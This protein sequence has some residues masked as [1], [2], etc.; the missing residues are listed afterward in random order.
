MEKSTNSGTGVDQKAYPTFWPP[1][2]GPHRRGHPLTLPHRAAVSRAPGPDRQRPHGLP[3][4]LL[5]DRG[6]RGPDPRP[7]LHPEIPAAGGGPTAA[8]TPRGQL[9]PDAAPR[10]DRA[11]INGTR[12]ART[13]LTRLID[14]GRV[15]SRG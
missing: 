12:T 11:Q 8:A 7:A 6:H 1:P 10:Q 9:P 4:T 15:T 3:I 13:R 2:Q 5:A 14:A